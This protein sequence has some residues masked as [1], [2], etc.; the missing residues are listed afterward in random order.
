VREPGHLIAVAARC[1]RGE[2]RKTAG[3]LIHEQ[4]DDLAVLR[5]Q[6]R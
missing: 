4:G 2:G 3:H 5:A 6:V 1:R